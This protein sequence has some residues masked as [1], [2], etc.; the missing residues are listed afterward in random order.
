M[1]KYLFMSLFAAFIIT[2]AFAGVHSE[3]PTAKVSSKSVK[4]YMKSAENGD[5]VAQFQLGECY[6][7]GLGVKK[8][9]KK[10]FTY[11]KKSA[12]QGYVPAMHALSV[13]YLYGVGCNR[14]IEQALWYGEAAANQNYIKSV[15]GMAVAYSGVGPVDVP[16]DLVKAEKYARLG[17]ELKDPLSMYCLAKVLMLKPDSSEAD[18]K[19][20]LM[21][22]QSSAENGCGEAALT[23]AKL[24]LERGPLPQDYAVA[25]KWLKKADAVGMAE[26]SYL[27]AYCSFNNIGMEYDDI[28]IFS[29][30]EK[31]A[32]AGYAPA[33]LSLAKVYAEGNDQVKKSYKKARFWLDKAIEQGLEEAIEYSKELE[34]LRK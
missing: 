28:V 33:Q 32:K 11:Y 3:V 7:E 13:C 12:D 25:I 16:I 23:L 6:R 1:F 18:K 14:N 20:S 10:A 31:S 24:Y 17:S 21:L 22:L 15:R 34:T 5:K 30:I 27:L 8:D 26:A 4:S 9:E 2:P 19:E 29:Y